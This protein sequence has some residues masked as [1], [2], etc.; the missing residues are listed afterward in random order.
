MVDVVDIIL[1]Q[2]VGMSDDF[3][4]IKNLLMKT[5]RVGARALKPTF[6]NQQR[7][8]GALHSD[9]EYEFRCY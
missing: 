2:L 3:K 5:F 9:V 8:P 7:K 4:H 1:Q 6:E